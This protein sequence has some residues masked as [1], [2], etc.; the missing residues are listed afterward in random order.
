MIGALKVKNNK[1]EIKLVFGLIYS[2]NLMIPTNIVCSTESYVWCPWE[3]TVLCEPCYKA[4]MILAHRHDEKY[5]HSS[6]LPYILN[7]IKMPLLAR[8]VGLSENLGAQGP[9]QN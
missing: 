6:M 9:F 7:L 3:L 8:R 1:L 2:K 5:S 4:G